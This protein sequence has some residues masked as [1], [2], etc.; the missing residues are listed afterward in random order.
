MLDL[1]PGPYAA[2]IWPAYGLTA[3]VF[4]GMIAASLNRARRWRKKAESLTRGPEA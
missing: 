1:D 4:L 3:L 2:F